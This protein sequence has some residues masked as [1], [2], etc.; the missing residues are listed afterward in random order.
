LAV[1]P[2]AEDYHSYSAYNYVLGNPIMNWDP[3]GMQVEN[4]YVRFKDS[5]GDEQY[6][7]VGT[8]GGND[9]DVIY[10]GEI[11]EDGSLSVDYSDAE[12]KPVEIENTSGP[13]NMSLSAQKRNPTPGIREEH[14]TT[15][16]VF[17]AI[18][19]LFGAQAIGFT[20]VSATLGFALPKPPRGRGAVPPNKRDPK[21]VYS[22]SEK[23]EMLKNQG[24]RC[25]QCNE[26]KTVDE[27]HGHHIKRHSD[28]GATSK[29]NGAAVCHPCHKKLH[30]KE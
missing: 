10:E 1:D 6:R 15:P 20:N 24:G 2:L 14:N 25:A 5:S 22:K 7:L 21:R 8:E 4:E 12:V 9:Y 29:D 19:A 30:K 13:G 16:L 23:A 28:G 26:K 27:V 17:R 3:D 18:G 11:N